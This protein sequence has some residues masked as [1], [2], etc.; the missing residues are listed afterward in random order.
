[1]CAEMTKVKNVSLSFVIPVFNEEESLQ[2]LYQKIVEVM[3]SISVKEYEIIFIDD[4][5]TD[6]SWQHIVQLH[7]QEK[8][9]VRGFKLRRNFGKAS[10]LALGFAESK[11]EIVFTLDADLQDD[12]ENIPAFLEK[13]GSG[14]D[15]ISGWKK[16][17]KDPFEKKIASKVFNFFVSLTTGLKLNDM[18]CGFKAYRNEVLHHINLYGELHRYIPVLAHNAGFSVTEIPV[19]HS[20]R[21]FG[22]SKY[23]WERYFKGFFDLLTVLF[24]TR[25]LQRPLHFFGLGGV[26]MGAAGGAILFFLSIRKIFWGID[27]EARPLFFLGILCVL[28]SGQLLSLGIL[29]ELINRLA[30]KPDESAK[31]SQ[32]I[33]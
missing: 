27:I 7:S 12:P 15:V 4:G 19:T 31:V 17:R 11:G 14:W 21:K 2:T 3:D 25:F 10:G 9:K 23:G 24:I 5:S 6:N 28:F 33:G 1:M 13:L 8:K 26:V 29:G 32:Q 30:F 18:N 22:V 20:P 16:E